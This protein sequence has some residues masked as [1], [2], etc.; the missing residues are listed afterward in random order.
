V[1][2]GVENLKQDYGADPRNMR[3]FIAVGI[4][5]DN[6]SHP[7][8]LE[9]FGGNEELFEK[10]ADSNRRM[11][12]FFAEYGEGAVVDHDDGTL[13]LTEIIKYQ[14]VEAGMSVANID[15]DGIDTFGDRNNDGSYTWW[16]NRHEDCGR[17][18]NL[19]LVVKR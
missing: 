10:Y 6:F 4:A 7:T 12:D 8:T 2:H 19:V 16:S 18:R 13:D 5:P 3:G 14:M 11:I 15:D 17:Q 9:G 1:T